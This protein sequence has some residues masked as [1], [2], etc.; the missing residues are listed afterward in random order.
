MF[1]ITH[2]FGT[3]SIDSVCFNASNKET[4]MELLNN[5]NILGLFGKFVEF[6][7]KSFKY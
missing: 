1:S 7:H 3:L 6:G 4:V 5:C 2:S